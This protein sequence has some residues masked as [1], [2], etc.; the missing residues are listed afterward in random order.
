MYSRRLF[1]RH[2]RAP[3]RRACRRVSSDITA[4]V[5]LVSSPARLCQSQRRRRRASAERERVV[6]PTVRRRARQARTDRAVDTRA[7]CAA[8]RVAVYQVTS[9]RLSSSSH[10]RLGSVRADTGDVERAPSRERVVLPTERRQPGR[11]RS[12][13]FVD[14]RARRTVVRAAMCR[15]A[16]PRPSSLSH[17][18]LGSVRASA[19]DA[20]RASSR[21]RVV[22]PTERCRPVVLAPIISSTPTLAVPSCVPP[23]V[24]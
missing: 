12:D 24:E 15:V 5:L 1:C 13:R 3:Y 14:T 20:E 11:A 9:P 16:S 10:R 7:R 4:P 21:E 2:P 22:L 18:R 23:C 19:G 17:G 6:V 8:V